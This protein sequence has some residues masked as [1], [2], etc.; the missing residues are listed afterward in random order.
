MF[1]GRDDAETDLKDGLLRG[2]VFRPN[3]AYEEVLSGRKSLIIGRK[4]SGKSAICRQLATARGHPGA[5]VLITPDDAAGDEIRRFEL[6]G[7]TADTAK[8]LIWRYVFAVHAARHL[9]GHARTGH[10]RRRLPSAVRALRRFLR[11]NGEYDDSRL[12]DRLRRGASGLQSANL[13][14]KAFGAEAALGVNGAS[15]GA[16]AGRQLEVLE[17]GVAAAFAELGC[18]GS[19]PPL[20]FLV[21]QLEQVWTVDADSHALVA[22]LLLA[23]KHATGHY[24]SAVRTALFLRSDIYDTLNFS[25]G[26]KFHSDEIRISWSRRGLEDVAL[27]RARASLGVEIGEEQLWGEVFPS[28]VRGEPTA[29]YLFRRALPRPRDAIQFLNACRGAAHE[30]G[31]P[32][33]T[34]ADVLAATERFSRWKLQDL[35][36]EYLVNHPFLRALFAMFENSAH[37]VTREVLE[38]RFEGR[39]DALHRDY[40]D[41]T[42]S[43]T[44]RGLIDVLYGAGFL[45]VRR[46][47][48]VV[49]SGGSQAPPG[50]GEDEFHVHPCFRPALG[51]F[52]FTQQPWSVNRD[53]GLLSELTESCD[54]LMRQVMRSQ[55]PEAVR[56][57][58]DERV[59][60]IARTAAAERRRG[61]R[62]GEVDAHRYVRDFASR[63]LILARDLGAM[64][65]GQDPLARRLESEARSLIRAAG[66]AQGSGAG[67]SS[68]G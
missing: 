20:L 32:W 30:R 47:D 59:R 53:L 3:H 50:P 67:S 57:R 49:Y 8:S 37:V 33:I 1:F 62:G 48:G 19:H 35:A 16:R 24:G 43:L 26:D 64:G 61:E 66:G 25:E 31:G 55:A 15:E 40:P 42:D 7:V 58:V 13:S 4:G 22:G 68:G 36:K 60:A 6:Q 23:A 27:A 52:V 11:A 17:D 21:D 18:D 38:S 51:G 5:S 14:L 65:F 28:V 54:R 56:I 10:H 46:G 39:R 29:D 12:Y 44:V 9:T 45:G 34:E 63:F 41:Y 2:A